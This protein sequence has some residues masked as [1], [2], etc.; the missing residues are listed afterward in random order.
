ML[1]YQI[2]LLLMINPMEINGQLNIERMEKSIELTSKIVRLNLLATK[3]DLQ[4]IFNDPIS[5][6]FPPSS[7]P[8]EQI[9][10][11]LFNLMNK[12]HNLQL[13]STTFVEQISNSI[14]YFPNVSS[15]RSFNVIQLINQFELISNSTL[16][17]M[18]H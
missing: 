5:V 14:E 2:F 3:C 17:T 10:E 13:L 11:I 8:N 4:Q 6:N 9:N 7:V 16:V 18:I 1:F 15:N 12:L